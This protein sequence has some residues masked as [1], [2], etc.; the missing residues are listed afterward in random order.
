MK[1]TLRGLK[2]GLFGRLAHIAAACEPYR[3]WRRF[4][5]GAEAGD[6]SNLISCP[7][8][9]SPLSGKLFNLASSPAST[10]CAAASLAMV[11]PLRA[12]IFVSVALATGSESGLAR[13]QLV[14]LR[15][16]WGT[17]P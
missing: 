5:A 11:S 12:R 6:D 16:P 17:T 8:C 3:W 4:G 2:G 9:N 1:R 7:A 15:F 13:R 14:S 10:L